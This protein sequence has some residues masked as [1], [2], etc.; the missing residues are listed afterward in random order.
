MKPLLLP[1]LLAIALAACARDGAGE[2]TPEAPL[3]S[4]PS[5]PVAV[6]TPADQSAAEPEALADPADVA[7]MDARIDR[8]L[9]GH[10]AYRTMLERLQVAVAGGDCSGVAALVRYP[11]EATGRTGTL[12]IRNARAFVEHCDDIV[13]PA[14]ARAIAEQRY[15]RLFVSQNGVMLGSGQVWINGV[16]QDPECVDVDV[17]VITFQHG[18]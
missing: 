12:R 6:P 8:V 5:L 4:A 16:C 17:K 14:V 15:A 11:L 3:I 18:S 1:T 9:G 7:A 10:L 2:N 13:T